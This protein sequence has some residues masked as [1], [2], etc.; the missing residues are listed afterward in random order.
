MLIAWCYQTFYTESVKSITISAFF[1]SPLVTPNSNSDLCMFTFRKIK[2]LTK[3]CEIFVKVQIKAN[4][5][6]FIDI[7]S[8]K[9][10]ISTPSAATAATAKQPTDLKRPNK[11][12]T[13]PPSHLDGFLW[14]F[15]RVWLI[16]GATFC[17]RTS[18]SH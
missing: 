8:R 11:T 15:Q 9:F 6:S 18:P 13:S 1:K 16:N 10:A 5:C 4:N 17:T 2:T 12:K 7:Y 14:K 3:M